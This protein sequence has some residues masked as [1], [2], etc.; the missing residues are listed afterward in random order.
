MDTY[1]LTWTSTFIHARLGMNKT[2]DAF[3]MIIYNQETAIG[4]PEV[5]IGPN[6]VCWIDNLL[7]KNIR[8]KGVLMQAEPETMRNTIKAGACRQACSQIPQHSLVQRYIWCL[9][10]ASVLQEG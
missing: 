3:G 7:L 9:S 1:G 2:P 4:L 6:H 5:F 10:R 8:L